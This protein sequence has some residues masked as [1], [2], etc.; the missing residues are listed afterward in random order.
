M[1]KA[2]PTD[3]VGFGEHSALSYQE[4]LVNQPAYCKQ[5]MERIYQMSK[6][7]P[8][9][10]VGFGEHSALS[11]QEI[12]VNQPAY[13]KWVIQTSSE[14]QCCARLARLATWLLVTEGQTGAYARAGGHASQEGQQCQLRYDCE[15]YGCFGRCD[16]ADDS[17]NGRD[18]GRDRRDPGAPTQEGSEERR[19]GRSEL[20]ESSDGDLRGPQR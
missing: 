18:E 19:D 20:M 11:Y 4:I 13:C 9:D 16:A 17:E 10:P 2:D 3:P 5:A 15:Q 12:L 8:T 14:G 6:A 1:S 7:D